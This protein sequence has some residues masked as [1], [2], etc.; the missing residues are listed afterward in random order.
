MSQTR[1]IAL[2]VG[3]LLGGL[4]IA[5]LVDDLEIGELFN[6]LPSSLSSLVLLLLLD[7]FLS[8]PR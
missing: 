4:I 7:A 2:T 3:I 8:F 6:S 1:Y 5:L